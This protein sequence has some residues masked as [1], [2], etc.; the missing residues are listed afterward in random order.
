[1]KGLL[2][3]QYLLISKN[4]RIQF[5]VMFFLAMTN[6]AISGLYAGLIPYSVVILEQRYKW[7]KFV[8]NLPV[9]SHQIV[10]ANYILGFVMVLMSTCTS[11]IGLVL[12][13]FSTIQDIS[14]YF[15]GGFVIIALTLP[16]IY[17]F[18]T[19]AR[20]A[21]S[22]AILLFALFFSMNWLESSAL[23]SVVIPVGTL[24]L[25]GTS[26]FLSLGFYSKYQN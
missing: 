18:G 10:A 8:K 6:P 26:F 21:M 9:S 14:F 11:L 1:M 13:E 4:L 22:V 24:V 25:T 20:G 2:Y 15:W 7:G 19:E 3:H 23:I 17:R 5:F 12:F 16:L